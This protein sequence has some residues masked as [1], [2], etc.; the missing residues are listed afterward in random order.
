MRKRPASDKANA[1]RCYRDGPIKWQDGEISGE[2]PVN[3][4]ESSLPKTVGRRQRRIHRVCSW[5]LLNCKFTMRKNKFPSRSLAFV[6]LTSGLTTSALGSE[7]SIKIPVLTQVTFSG[8]AG[9]SGVTLMYLGIVMCAFGAAFG[10]YQ[11]KQT[12]RVAG[13]QEH[14]RR[15][16]HH[17]GDLQ[18]LPFPAG[19]VPCHPLGADRRLHGVLLRG[20]GRKTAVR[21]C[22]SSSCSR[23][24]L[25]ILGSYGVAWFGIRINTVANSRTAFSALKG[26]PLKTL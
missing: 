18:D 22:W 15:V 6:L 2:W 20:A 23:S 12:K 25:G 4:G 3:F 17:L 21:R 1:P 14:E 9:I 19:Q 24:I 11:Y 5:H 8:L 26:N 10:L 7:A 13:A 16:E